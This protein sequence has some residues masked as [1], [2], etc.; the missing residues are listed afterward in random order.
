MLSK[1]RFSCQG[2]AEAEI[3]LRQS[4]S[5][6]LSKTTVS[7]SPKVH[8][9]QY[10][11]CSGGPI[12]SDLNG[13]FIPGNPF[14]Y[15]PANLPLAHSVT[16]ERKLQRSFKYVLLIWLNVLSLLFPDFIVLIGLQFDQ[17]EKQW[18]KHSNRWDDLSMNKSFFFDFENICSLNYIINHLTCNVTIEKR[19]MNCLGSL[20]SQNLS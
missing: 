10:T 8:P 9:C 4:E 3:F 18:K 12:L 19:G 6:C 17:Q 7:G 20:P 1:L 16:G 11:S 15:C 2:R 14:D 13:L 5:F